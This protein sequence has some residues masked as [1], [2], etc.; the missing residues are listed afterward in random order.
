MLTLEHVIFILIMAVA[1]TTISV[2]SSHMKIVRDMINFLDEH[3]EAIMV[4]VKELKED[5]KKNSK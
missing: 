2:I 5:T 4:L 3:K 1:T